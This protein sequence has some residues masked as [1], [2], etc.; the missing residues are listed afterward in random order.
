MS[1][2][3]LI[4]HGVRDVDQAK[5]LFGLIKELKGDI[6]YSSN[7][8]YR[9]YISIVV[10]TGSELLRHVSDRNE[11]ISTYTYTSYISDA[12]SVVYSGKRYSSL[13]LKR[14]SLEFEPNAQKI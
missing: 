4:V 8:E 5:E 7:T 13:L 2:V 10:I 9:K 6:D 11:D 3:V 12:G 14:V 1:P